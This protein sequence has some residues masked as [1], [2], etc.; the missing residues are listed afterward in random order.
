VNTGNSFLLLAVDSQETLGAL[1]PDL[2]AVNE[3]SETLDL[4]GYYP[5]AL[6]TQQPDRQAAA[7]MF[8][9]RYGIPEEAGTGMAAGPLAC[10]LHEA[11]GMRRGSYLLEQGWH[12][13]PPS[14]CA[15]TVNLTVGGSGIE[16]LMAGGRA[17]SMRTVDVDL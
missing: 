13:Q 5:F 11:L 2:P 14:P 7:R 17:K 12:M 9:P 16:G 6:A 8:A 1:R 15:I 4:V 3:V 10:W